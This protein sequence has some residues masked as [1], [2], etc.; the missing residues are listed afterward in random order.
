MYAIKA[1][2]VNPKMQNMKDKIINRN[3]NGNLNYSSDKEFALTLNGNDQE[4]FNSLSGIERYL[5]RGGDLILDEI[6]QVRR[7]EF[8]ELC[9]NDEPETY[10][11]EEASIAEKLDTILINL[12]VIE[13]AIETLADAI[14]KQPKPT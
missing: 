12:V 5:V 14:S 8:A 13:N 1:H 7:A 4:F 11:E 10:D 6:R 3:N 2:Q 9:E